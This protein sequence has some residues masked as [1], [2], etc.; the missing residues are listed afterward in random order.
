M[1]KIIFFDIDDTLVKH[2]GAE[3]KSLL[4][5]RKRYFPDVLQREFDL[6][7]TENSRKFWKLFVEKKLTFGNQRIKRIQAV[8]EHFG[9]QVSK[10]KAERIFLTY[11]NLYE[12]N[13]SL[14]FGIKKS[15]KVLKKKGIRLGII[16][17]G[18]R[19]QQD[20]KLKQTGI[21]QLLDTELIIVSEEVG[22]AKP[23]LK[24]F[25][26]AQKISGLSSDKILF[27]GNDM[28]QD[29]EPAR[30]MNWEVILVDSPKKITDWTSK[31]YC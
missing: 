2:T 29:I 28:V 18:N 30:E 27:F 11:L 17:N 9:K 23:D 8:W 4:A 24:I 16:S 14:F 15:L 31:N 22:F 21:Y 26:H 5:V 25:E 3:K 12:S 7:W 10:E 6:I 1:K 20:K 19:A 13:W